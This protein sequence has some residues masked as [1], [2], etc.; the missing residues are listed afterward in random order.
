MLLLENLISFNCS[1]A[2][3]STIRNLATEGLNITRDAVGKV[4]KRVRGNDRRFFSSSKKGEVGEW[5]RQL[6]SLDKVEVTKSSNNSAVVLTVA[7]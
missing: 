5:K 7:G 3:M 4:M 2:G 1:E 6:H